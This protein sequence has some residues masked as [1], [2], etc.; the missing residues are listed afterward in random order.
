MGILVGVSEVVAVVPLEGEAPFGRDPQFW[1]QVL[2]PD[3][4]E[5]ALGSPRAPCGAAP[6]LEVSVIQLHD[7]NRGAEERV[8]STRTTVP[9]TAP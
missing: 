2:S 9:P 7:S 5:G 8:K 1:A 3:G 4:P 6:R